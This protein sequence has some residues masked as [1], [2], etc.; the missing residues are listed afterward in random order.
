MKYR[1]GW[2][3][4]L[5]IV[6]LFAS[7][8]NPPNP[9]TGSIKGVVIDDSTNVPVEGVTVIVNELS[10]EDATDSLGE[11]LFNDIEEG[12]YS[13]TI[14]KYPFKDTTLSIH[15]EGNETLNV[16]VRMKYIGPANWY[17][18]DSVG[19]PIV[20]VFFI[21]YYNGW[22]LAGGDGIWWGDKIYRAIDGKHFNL[23][24][25]FPAEDSVRKIFFENN[26]VGWAVGMKIWKTEDGGNTWTEQLNVDS[27][28]HSQ[29]YG[30]YFYNENEG[31]VVGGGRSSTAD[32]NLVLHTLD[33]GGTWEELEPWASTTSLYALF[34]IKMKGDWGII[35]GQQTFSSFEW[36]I[37][38]TFYTSDGGQ[39]WDVALEG[40]GTEMWHPPFH[41]VTLY[42]DGKAI[43]LWR[44]GVLAAKSEDM[45]HSWF[46]LDT[47]N[48]P[49]YDV[50]FIDEDHGWLA[51]ED[52]IYFTG[53]E[54]TTWESQ[55]TGGRVTSLYMLDSNWGYAGTY[56]GY[57]LRYERRR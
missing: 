3:I 1:G 16:E 8:K 36:I 18:V 34:D 9:A 46:L 27:I 33:G 17:V 56:E 14:S 39:N 6:V 48:A 11:F 53:D 15:V 26:S 13:L 49:A 2:S 57:I 28:Y 24:Y 5:F 54:G 12:D 55:W 4:P 22:L 47:L 10:K 19:N 38:G 7:C 32:K 30:L 43:K 40:F 51:S 23:V 52:G 37:S 45:G 20:Q 42:G 50:F 29:A 44:G 35:V 41:R 21:D 25:Q 31:F